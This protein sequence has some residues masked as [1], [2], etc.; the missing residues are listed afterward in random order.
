MCWR[1]ARACRKRIDS[2][3]LSDTARI[4]QINSLLWVKVILKHVVRHQT[5][6]TC[7]S[8]QTHWFALV[9]WLQ[10]ESVGSFAILSA[11]SILAALGCAVHGL[12]EC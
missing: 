1:A 2:T 12:Q 7:T 4:L 6:V 3:P 9:Q 5:L 8:A 11:E 10:Q